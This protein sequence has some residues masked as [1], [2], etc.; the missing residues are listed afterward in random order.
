MENI[1]L[2]MVVNERIRK[3]PAFKELRQKSLREFV[4]NFYPGL[5]RKNDFYRT[6]FN[7][8]KN[9]DPSDG[10]SVENKPSRDEIE[11]CILNEAL[12]FFTKL[13][14]VVEIL[15]MR[16]ERDAYLDSEKTHVSSLKDYYVNGL[17]KDQIKERNGVTSR[18]AVE[19]H[20]NKFKNGDGR[21]SVNRL[22]PDKFKEEISKYVEKLNYR[23]LSTTQEEIGFVYSEKNLRLLNIIGLDVVKLYLNDKPKFIVNVNDDTINNYRNTLTAVLKKLKGCFSF[24]TRDELLKYFPATI[25][26]EKKNVFISNLVASLNILEENERGIRVKTEFLENISIRQARIIYDSNESLRNEEIKRRYKEIY[27]EDMPALRTGDLNEIGFFCGGTEWKYGEKPINIRTFIKEYAESH[28]KFDYNDLLAE[29]KGIGSNLNEN[30]IETYTLDIC[31][32]SLDDINIMVHKEHLKD[33]P[34]IR[35]AKDIRKGQKNIALNAIW[36]YMSGM[37]G[38]LEKNSLIEWIKGYLKRNNLDM[39]VVNR[40]LKYDLFV[41]DGNLVKLNQAKY[42]KDDL[43]YYGLGKTKE[44][45]ANTVISLVVNELQKSVNKTLPFADLQ[46][47]IRNNVGNLSRNQIINIIESEPDILQ[48]DNVNRRLFVKLIKEIESCPV[49]EI[50]T[51][52]TPDTQPVFV[53]VKES[54]ERLS[55]DITFDWDRLEAKMEKELRFYIRPFWFGDDFDLKGAIKKFRRFME[56]SANANLYYV[57]PQNLYEYWFCSTSQYD[58]NRYFCDLARCYETVLKEL[59]CQHNGNMDNVKGLKDMCNKYYPELAKA[60]KRSDCET[61][62]S[63]ALRSLKYNRDKIAHGDY[64]DMSSLTEAQMISNYIALYVFTVK[65]EGRVE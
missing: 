29:I 33:F 17:T 24:I 65:T 11:V 55:A 61:N 48:L 59:Y 23:Y 28:I 49:Y 30:S 38:R 51:A 41:V 57:I 20:I 3:N 54:R 4:D 31:K 6:I 36:D 26:P 14:R 7:M 22:F 21:D 37:G 12:P 32:R 42:S 25:N 34:D 15:I 56:S 50:E 40:I 18:Q 60:F 16:C 2:S 10:N 27:N 64:V 43:K 53:E 47:I 58:R 52:T 63:K 39:G 19:N 35:F 62:I 5:H 9:Y 44:K 1:R 46:D 45:Y 13:Q 8:C